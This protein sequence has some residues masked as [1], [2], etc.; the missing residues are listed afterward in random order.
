MYTPTG[1]PLQSDPIRLWPAM[2][3]M[4]PNHFAWVCLHDLDTRRAIF[5]SV[6]DNNRSAKLAQ[7]LICNSSSALEPAALA[8]LPNCLPIGPL[9][10]STRLAKQAGHFWPEN[11]TCLSWLDQQPP[12]SV[13][14]VAFG[15]FTVFDAAQFQELASGLELAG[16][17]FLWVVRQDITVEGAGPPY[18][19]GFEERV[20]GR[21]KMVEW[22]PQ[23]EVLSH[24][25]VACFVSHCGWNSTMESVSNGVPVLCWPYFADQFLNE[26][27]IVDHWEV[28]VRLEKDGGGIIGREE[29]TR[30]VEMVLGDEGY[31]K[32]IVELQ[33]K[34]LAS[35]VEGGSSH[36]NLCD[37]MDWIKEN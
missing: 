31:K 2:P 10:A 18:P 26:T 19:D 14:Y 13:V 32:R 8:F 9:L 21:G 12:N 28:G 24:P 23:Q 37:F 34:T 4:N 27:Y 33:E 6:V 5:Q 11:P 1:T 29:I 30:K 7:F 20:R 17:P 15:S 3:A 22:A 25:S 36:R 16:M 35:S